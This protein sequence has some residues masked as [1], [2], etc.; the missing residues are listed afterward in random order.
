MSVRTIKNACYINRQN[1][2]IF[3]PNSFGEALE[4]SC[5]YHFCSFTTI[6]NVYSSVHWVLVRKHTNEPNCSNRA[7]HI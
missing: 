7:E 4:Q 1:C 6:T 2:C 5:L 3:C